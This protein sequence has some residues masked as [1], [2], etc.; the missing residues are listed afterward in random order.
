[1]IPRIGYLFWILMLAFGL[2]ILVVT[3]Q[4]LTH[5]NINGLKKGNSEAAITF[6]INNRL[7]DI[8]NLSFELESKLTNPVNRINRRQS[9]I[10]SLTMLGYNASVLQDINLNEEA[11]ARF[12]KLNSFIDLQIQTSMNAL[13][14]P[15]LPVSNLVDS[16]RKMR[17]TDSI[18]STALSIQK[19]L[20]KDLGATLNNN[21]RVSSQL[22]SY[23][24]VLA[25]IA[26]AA[27]LIL[28]TIIINRHLRQVQLITD[29]E[30]ATEVA[31]QSALIKDQFLANMSHEIRTP[32]NAI[33]GFSGLL[34]QT[35]LNNEQQQYSSIINDASG[36]LM[37]IVNDI[38]DISRIEAGKLRIEIKEFNLKKVMQ[39]VENMFFNTAVGKGLQYFQQ[40]GDAV[41]VNLK[42]DP[43]RLS[44]VLINLI[45]NAVKFTQN[46]YINIITS[47][48]R[49]SS[50]RVWIKF[51]VNDTGI[52]IPK[53]KQE[54]IFQRF[55][56]LNTGKENVIQGTGLGLS[57][58]KSLVDKMGGDITVSSEPGKGSLFSVVL[59]FEMVTHQIS[60]DHNFLSKQVSS[61]YYTGASVLVVEDN[62]INQLL[63]KHTLSAFDITVDITDNGEEAL[64]AISKKKYD[65]VLLDIQMPVLD[66]YATIKRIR[67]TGNVPVVAMT[68]Y[69]MPGEKEKCLKAGMDEYLA[70]P[71]DFKLLTEVLEKYLQAKRN[72][73]EKQ[74]IASSDDGNN[75]LLELAGGDK[76][77][78]ARILQEI[79]QE[80]PLA[81]SRLK[82]LKQENKKTEI[83]SACHYLMSTFFPLGNE[84]AVVKKLKQLKNAQ[85]GMEGF[86]SNILLID[87]L[88]EEIDGINAKLEKMI[89][90]LLKT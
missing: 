2:M 45:S 66:G 25:I 53:E 31:K 80:I 13:N 17:I 79:K 52:G 6:T 81:I 42:G 1:M 26:I 11:T 16:L 20:E 57:I 9:V 8:V 89:D 87:K 84:S 67:N 29:L 63:L 37:N 85:E 5:R 90:G 58:V 54:L 33:K 41:P 24:K 62:K 72:G 32:L 50:D 70:K 65:L 40:M 75:F 14:R 7:Q 73:H 10:D 61:L 68:A 12:K 27:V 86:D 18:Y 74:E 55:E 77:I 69:A 23:N 30:K 83:S 82:A 35:Q 36:N 48:H 44:Q 46:G 60:E 21:T 76:T 15:G 43:D 39:S 49:K 4:I 71:V 51:S 47:L 88:V 38:L 19:Y 59:P 3:A 22:S 78:A 28:G 56:Q 34:S 64:A